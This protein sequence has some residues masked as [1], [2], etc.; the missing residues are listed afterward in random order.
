[1]DRICRCI[2]LFYSPNI[3]FFGDSF[4]CSSSIILVVHCWL[5]ISLLSALVIYFCEYPLL[6]Y[7]AGCFLWWFFLLVCLLLG[8]FFVCFRF[9]PIPSLSW[10]LALMQCDPP[11][12]QC[13]CS[14]PSLMICMISP[15]THSHNTP[16]SHQFRLQ[17]T[18]STLSSSVDLFS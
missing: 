17:N 7:Y 8:C 10:A 13:F 1:M 12:P 5:L 4:H 9:S 11:Q 15:G 16:S 18:N 2:I 6:Q 14:F 3:S